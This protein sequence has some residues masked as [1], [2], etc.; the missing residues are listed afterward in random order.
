M[1]RTLIGNIR[2]PKGEQGIQ[3]PQGE[4][5]P[6]GLTGSQGIQGEQGPQGIQGEQGIQ[7]PKGDNGYTPIKGTDYF[8]TED[9]NSLNIPN[10]NNTKNNSVKDTYSCN[11]IDST[12]DGTVLYENA[13]GSNGTITLNESS[14]NFKYMKIFYKSNYNDYGSL[15]VSQPDGKTPTISMVDDNGNYTETVFAKYTRYIISGNQIS[16][17]R[18]KWLEIGTNLKNLNENAMSIYKVVGYR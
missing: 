16:I 2:G 10:V 7:G 18:Q 15:E 4:Q 14:A 9:I 11:Y 13:N 17:V 12:V 8:T 1:A 5:G 3:G 6:I